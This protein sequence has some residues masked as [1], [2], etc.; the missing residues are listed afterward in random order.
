MK[1]LILCTGN[2][3]RSQMAEGFLKS[4]DNKL[5]VVSAGTEPSG[6]VHPKAIQVMN[7]LDIDLSGNYPKSVNEFLENSFDYVI[8]VCGGA[9]ESC[10]MFTGKVEH[11]LHIGFDDP[12]EAEGPEEFILS[13]FRRIRN[14]IQR[15]FKKFYKNNLTN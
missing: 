1:I 6:Q 14:E 3:C 15:D 8:T 12:A 5:K 13:E 2:S 10:P 4:F 7:E 9:K 11:S